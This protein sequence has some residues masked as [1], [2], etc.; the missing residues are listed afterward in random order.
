LGG[1]KLNAG[2]WVMDAGYWMLD[3]LELGIGRW[4]IKKLTFSPA[5]GYLII[6]T[7]K[8]RR[9]VSINQYF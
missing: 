9:F 5:L 4:E 1:N 2:G 7:G 8:E 3:V 6:L